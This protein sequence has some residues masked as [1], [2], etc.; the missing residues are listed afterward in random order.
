MNTQRLLTQ[1]NPGRDMAINYLKKFSYMA[2]LH[3][4]V[5]LMPPLVSHYN[6]S[7]KYRCKELGISVQLQLV[8]WCGTTIAGSGV[9]QPTN[10]DPHVYIKDNGDREQRIQR[11]LTPDKYFFLPITLHIQHFLPIQ[12]ALVAAPIT[13]CSKEFTAYYSTHQEVAT[14]LSTSTIQRYLLCGHGQRPF[15]HG[16]LS[17]SASRASNIPYPFYKYSL[18]R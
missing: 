18:K 3:I 15:T 8:D 14:G 16:C 10:A 12:R 11:S 2:H 13:M 4:F 7:G 5:P 6:A 17:Q 1:D 9:G